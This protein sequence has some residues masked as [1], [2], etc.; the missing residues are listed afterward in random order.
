MDNHHQSAELKYRLRRQ[1]SR[2]WKGRLISWYHKIGNVRVTDRISGDNVTYD[3]LTDIGNALFYS[4]A[5]EQKELLLC[6]KYLSD[7]S[8][9]L[10]IG[11]NIGLHSLYFST[12]AHAGTVISFEPSL[13]TFEFLAKNVKGKSNISPL[14]VAVSSHGGLLN[15]FQASDN[16]YSSLIDT[17][18]KSIV[19]VRRVICM[20]VDDVVSGLQLPRVDF[21]K[22]DVEGLESSVLQGM[23]K[24]IDKYNPVIFCEIYKGTASNP[25][26]EETI[27]FLTARD[28]MVYVMQNGG[29]VKPEKHDDRLYNYLF[30][31]KSM[32]QP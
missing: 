3:P 4:G 7:Q 10:D 19:N 1:A 25:S 31:P 12:V 6:R 14:N 29:L 9:V 28:Y 5:F 11:A 18:R 8:V 21:V 32:P 22:I 27:S 26:P 13:E 16:A 15:F 24:V 17:K 23:E 20:T 2:F 30:L